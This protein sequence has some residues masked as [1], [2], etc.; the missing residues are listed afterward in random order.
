M[1][2][3]LSVVAVV[4]AGT[5]FVTAPSTEDQVSSAAQDA[6]KVEQVAQQTTGSEQPRL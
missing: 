3:A 2:A 5:M 6:A 1:L 4:L